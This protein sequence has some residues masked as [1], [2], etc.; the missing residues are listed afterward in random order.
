MVTGAVKGMGLAVVQAF[1]QSGAAMA[2]ADIDVDAFGKEV[3]ALVK[4]GDKA[5]A[6]SCDVA[7]EAQ[8]RDIQ[9]HYQGIWPTGC[10]VQ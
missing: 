5:L 4:A 8:V 2:M 6:I 3:R 1:A 9:R 7:N 10:G